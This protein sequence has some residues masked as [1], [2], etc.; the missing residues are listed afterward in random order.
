M[1]KNNGTLRDP[2]DARP[3]AGRVSD[4]RVISLHDGRFYNILQLRWGT[5]G[6]REGAQSDLNNTV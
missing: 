1:A 2:T 3:Y 6:A 4:H 5:Y